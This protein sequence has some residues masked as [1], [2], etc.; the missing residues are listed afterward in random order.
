LIDLQIMLK[1]EVNMPR[2]R[3]GPAAKLE[4]TEA[5]AGWR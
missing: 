4:R 3:A 5:L 1:V 2:G